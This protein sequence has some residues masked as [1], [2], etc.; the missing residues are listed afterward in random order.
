M[1][2]LLSLIFRILA[3]ERMEKATSAQTAYWLSCLAIFPLSMLLPFLPLRRLEG[4]LPDPWN[5]IAAVFFL[6][7]TFVGL[8]IAVGRA[9]EKFPLRLLPVAMITWGMVAVMWWPKVS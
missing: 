2:P 3:G 8:M 5:V 4:I 9:F 7:V 6:G 1:N